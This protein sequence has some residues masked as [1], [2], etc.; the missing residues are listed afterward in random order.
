M[1][2]ATRKTPDESRVFRVAV[3]VLREHC[4]HLLATDRLRKITAA[5]EACES[6]TLEPRRPRQA[7]RFLTAKQIAQL[8]TEYEAGTS[9]RALG[10]AFGIHRRTVATLL[11]KSGITPRARGVSEE[12]L[13]L[14]RA[15]LRKGESIASIARSL[16]IPATTLRSALARNEGSL[17]SHGLIP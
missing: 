3:G 14:A 15:R 2:R 5:A 17:S 9:M 4:N 12:K 1:P 10:T 13:H 16:S 7:H 6:R 11:A 8:V